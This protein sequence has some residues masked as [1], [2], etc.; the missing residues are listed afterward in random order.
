MIYA[1]LVGL[2]GHSSGSLVWRP[3]RDECWA[4]DVEPEFVN[5][6]ESDS[7][8]DGVH[9]VPT[10][11]IF[12]DADP[13]GEPLAEHVGAA[14]ADTIRTL[15]EKGKS[16]AARDS[17]KVGRLTRGRDRRGACPGPVAG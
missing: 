9:T 10:I 17:G 7:R 12:D 4:A 6:T 3:F 8:A 5:V 15:L 13:Y 16:L 1:V 2:P 11:R 14:D